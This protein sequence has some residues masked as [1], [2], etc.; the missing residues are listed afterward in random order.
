[1]TDVTDMRALIAAELADVNT[2]LPGVIVE[3]DGSFATVQPTL[4]KQLANG[5][6]LPAPKIVRVPVCWPVGDVNGA[7]ALFTVPLKA[8]D[9]VL[10]TFSQRGLDEWLGGIDG[11]PGDPRQFDLSDCFASPMLRP[12]GL[13]ADTER[14]SLQYGPMTLKITAEGEVTLDTVAPVTVQTTATATV[15]APLVTVDALETVMT[16]NLTLAGF[17][18]MGT[19]GSGTG[20]R[21]KI[22]GPVEVTDGDLTVPGHN[23]VAQG[24][25]LATHKH[26]GVSTGGGTSGG[27]TP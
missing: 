21:A 15:K 22:R 27:P 14:V 6:T 4:A 23:V 8:G 16:G 11:A 13:V 7:Q 9:A 24:I 18:T 5:E 2:C 17:L 25:G 20:A 3:Y 12:G 26:T 19:G 1:M 10:L